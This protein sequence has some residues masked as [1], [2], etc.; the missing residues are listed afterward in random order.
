M[1]F[2]PARDRRD[3]WNKARGIPTIIIHVKFMTLNASQGIA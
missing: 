2:L 3:K 1:K